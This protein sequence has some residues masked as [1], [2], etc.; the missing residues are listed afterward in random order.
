MTGDESR[1][2]GHKQVNADNF[3]DDDPL[4]KHFQMRS[5]VGPF[6]EMASRDWV[7]EF[8]NTGLSHKV[9]QD[10]HDLHAVAKTLSAYGALYYPLFLKGLEEAYRTADAACKLRCGELG[11]PKGTFKGRIDRLKDYGLLTAD[12]H[13]QWT[14]FRKLRNASSHADE[15][16]VWLPGVCL[17]TFRDV[18]GAINRLFSIPAAA[19]VGR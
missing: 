18:T 3:T 11:K 6:R 9:P 19:L 4:L 2:A 8:T 7:R 13:D 16:T 5:P 10:I 12:E 17:S 15:A 14:G 1:L